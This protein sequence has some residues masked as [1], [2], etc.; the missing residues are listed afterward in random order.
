MSTRS[1]IDVTRCPQCGTS[2]FDETHD[3]LFRLDEETNAVRSIAASASTAP[4]IRCSGWS[5]P[6]VPC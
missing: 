3:T 2:V 6:V 4:T 5:T 1:P